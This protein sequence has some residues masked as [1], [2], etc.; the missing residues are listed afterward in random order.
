MQMICRI[1]HHD[2]KILDKNYF[3]NC[4]SPLCHALMISRFSVALRSEPQNY[5]GQ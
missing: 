2:E 4:I 5:L 3:L 1:N